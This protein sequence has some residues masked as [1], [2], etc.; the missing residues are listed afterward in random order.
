M[1]KYKKS[2]IYPKKV[3]LL[4]RKILFF[5]KKQVIIALFA[6]ASIGLTSCIT[7]TTVEEC[8]CKKETFDLSTRNSEKGW[9]F[10]AIARQ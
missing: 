7:G 2:C 6:L 1:Q 9:E 10:D 4:R 5:M 8:K 3:V